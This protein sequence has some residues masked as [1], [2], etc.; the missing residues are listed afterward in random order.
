MVLCS[1]LGLA[2][3]HILIK[4]HIFVKNILSL[5]Y[6]FLFYYKSSWFSEESK[7]YKVLGH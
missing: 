2:K 4:T 6:F 1:S 5:H 7:M 3:N